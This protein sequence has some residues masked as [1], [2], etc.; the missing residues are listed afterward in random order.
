MS[1]RDRE[2]VANLLREA[3][4]RLRAA[5]T[6]TDEAAQRYRDYLGTRG[7]TTSRFA[8]QSG[9]LEQVC[10]NEANALQVVIEQYLTPKTTARGP[11]KR[12]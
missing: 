7:D 10:R 2:S 6:S 8:H 1:N 9:Q 5:P 3:V 4:E 12:R 11:R